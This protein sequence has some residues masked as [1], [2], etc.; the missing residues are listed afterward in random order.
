MPAP[1]PSPQREAYAAPPKRHRG[2]L[3]V[4][5]I[6]ACVLGLGAGVVAADAAGLIDD[7]L[8]IRD[9]GTNV[10]GTLGS[11]DTDTDGS[12]VEVDEGVSTPIGNLVNGGYVCEDDDYVYYATPVTSASGWYTNGI[13]RASKT[14]S[15]RQTIYT[16]DSD[17][18]VIYHLNVESGRLIFTEVSG[19]STTVRSVGTDGSDA[20]TLALADDSSLLQVYKGRIYYLS[21]GTVKV[22]DPDGGN[23][24]DVLS[25]GTRLWRI[26]NDKVVSFDASN[27]Y[28]VDLDGS[29]SHTLISASQLGSQRDITNVIPRTDGSYEVFLGS[30]DEGGAYE[31]YSVDE[32]GTQ[33][34]LDGQAT[35][36]THINRANPT[37]AGTIVLTNHTAASSGS[38]DVPTD[39]Q[40]SVP[41]T[42][43]T[44]YE[45]GDADVDLCYPT[46]IDGFVY[47][48]SVE[49]GNNHLMRVPI[50]GG[51]TETVA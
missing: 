33:V 19:G 2:G 17:D 50:S 36:G 21:G 30:T 14:G 3:V 37:S 20:R 12:A 9:T 38:D 46:Y 27:V 1:V 24:E 15:D 44:L 42:G 49:K 40:V 10:V 39:E 5:V 8:G 11:Y 34:G 25:V 47:F 29:N 13:V 48:G 26:A 22:M 23:Q 28:I 41:G 31:L 16:N 35:S 43:V 51:S 7:F 18:T 45:T 32:T 6:V 4:L